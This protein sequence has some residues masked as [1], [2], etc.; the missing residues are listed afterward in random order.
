MATTLEMRTAYE[1]LE[2][3]L[4][5]LWLGYFEVGGNHDEDYLGAFMNGD[6]NDIDLVD[7]ITSST[8]STT[9]SSNGASITLS[10]TAP[11]DAPLTGS[12]WRRR[13]VIAFDQQGARCSRTGG[14]AMFEAADRLLVTT[15]DSCGRPGAR[16]GRDRLSTAPVLTAALLEEP[17]RAASRDRCRNGRRPVAHQDVR[18]GRTP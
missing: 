6:R 8:H 16:V 3:S 11:P 12:G 5:D 14:G 13:E 18:L 9:R 17:G 2:L 4:N 7:A 15:S 10:A 1:F